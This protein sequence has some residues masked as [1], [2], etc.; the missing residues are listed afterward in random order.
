MGVSGG[1]F[2]VDP[3]RVY[4]TGSSNGAFMTNRIGCQA[5]DLF[6]A[7][8][9][10]SGMIVNGIS[11]VWD[12]D[13]YDCPPLSKPLPAIYFHGTRDPLVRFNG[14]PQLGF[15]SVMS[16]VERM[17]D[18]NGMKG[19]DGTVSYKHGD[20]MCIAYGDV[21]SNFTFCK[22]QTGHCWPGTSQDPLNRC[23]KN[24]D[25]TSQIWSFFKNYRLGDG[26]GLSSGLISI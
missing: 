12:S 14:R 4:L 16:S 17:K 5:P 18:R 24:I 11:H 6:A 3:A 7:I 9:P 19:Q 26:T 8:A 10:V 15:P 21:A 1:A 23:T 25:A 20:V 13:P 2:E 22:H